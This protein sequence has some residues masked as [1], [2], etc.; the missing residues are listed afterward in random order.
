MQCKCRTISETPWY[1]HP[2][3]AAHC[4]CLFRL[5]GNTL[6]VGE[7]QSQSQTQTE[8]MT[9]NDLTQ[10]VDG[11]G[12]ILSPPHSRSPIHLSQIPWGKLMPTDPEFVAKDKN[13]VVGGI[14]LLPKA[15]EDP[16]RIDSK[17]SPNCETTISFLG[18]DGLT[19]RDV[20]N[21]YVLGRNGRNKVSIPKPPSVNDE[22]MA[23][24]NAWAHALISNRHCR[25]FC[26]L[27]DSSSN[28]TDA[29]MEVY[30]EDTSNNGTLVNGS[31]VLRRGEKRLLHTGDEICLLTPQTLRKKIRAGEIMNEIQ[32]H[33]TFIFINVLQQKGGAIGSGNAPTMPAP[34]PLP[35]QTYQDMLPPPQPLSSGRKRGGLVNVRG[36]ANH[37][38]DRMPSPKRLCPALDA[39]HDP[40]P[41]QSDEGP[42]PTSLSSS[43]SSSSSIPF[44]LLSDSG[45]SDPIEG[46]PKGNTKNRQGQPSVDDKPSTIL[47]AKAQTNKA[48]TEQQQHQQPPP[49][50]PLDKQ[51]QLAQSSLRVEEVYDIRDVLGTGTC[52]EVRRAI[53]RRTG[54]ERAVKIISFG[55]RNKSSRISAQVRAMIEA[56]AN[57]LRSLHHPY[58]V[59]LYDVFVAPGS[60]VYLV[61]EL[62]NG[63]DLF[64][65]I[66]AKGRYSEVES[67]RT[68]RRLLNAIYYLHEEQNVVHRDLKPEN[69]LC[70]SK[71]N[72][73]DVKLTD[74][75]VAKAVTDEGLKTFCGTPQYFAPEV[76]RRQH[77]IAGRGRYG[78]QA[79][80]WSVGVILYIL[81]SGAPPFDL[82]DGFDVVADAKVS[83]SSPEWDEISSEAIDLVKQCLK[84]DPSDRISAVDACNHPWILVDD[85]DSH[86]HPLDDPKSRTKRKRPSETTT[87]AHEPTLT[88]TKKPTDSPSMAA[89]S[90]PSLST[91]KEMD[92]NANSP[93]TR[94]PE[95]TSNGAHFLQKNNDGSNESL[96]NPV[97]PTDSTAT[98]K[99]EQEIP[100]DLHL[101]GNK[102]REI[103]TASAEKA[104]RRKVMKEHQK[105][106][107]SKAPDQS[108]GSQLVNDSDGDTARSPGDPVT[109][110]AIALSRAVTSKTS[111][112][113]GANTSICGTQS[114]KG[115][116]N[117]GK[118]SHPAKRKQQYRSIPASEPPSHDLSD[119]GIK[120]E[121]SDDIESISSFGTTECSQGGDKEK[122][123]VQASVLAASLS[124]S[125]SPTSNRSPTKRRRKDS[126]GL[127]IARKSKKRT[128]TSRR[129][130]AT[131]TTAD[132]ND[133]IGGNK[134]TKL[135]AWFSPKKDGMNTE[136][137]AISN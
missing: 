4:V 136:K 40:L 93:E 78:K 131:N 92:D 16:S 2:F 22:R 48:S 115:V 123:T 111:K 3:L 81:L 21:E 80:M 100:T 46:A 75:G 82:T 56:E 102:F 88:T 86:R 51:T 52:G 114:T 59:K 38:I 12:S 50:K 14:D 27:K 99:L 28:S 55:G 23:R 98:T 69:I 9:Q 87:P 66:V 116:P 42:K 57:I 84:A 107:V 74:F 130:K 36:V 135:S 15:P 19:K 6:Q 26:M 110:D 10:L 137:E 37:S 53:H 18:L 73:I 109:T 13:S 90:S 49:H 70:V 64:D 61:M 104:N 68:M 7:S 83:Y 60:A 118:D 121:F 133:N 65:R 62:M 5:Y 125:S 20:F 31:T 33:Y 134:Q 67:R 91:E 54:E 126:N 101:R 47:K 32:R 128:R 127:D 43:S 77:T 85:G 105:A 71:T 58:I 1:L 95:T 97:S 39:S 29:T 89:P 76:L 106:D 103:I 117:D 41:K 72:D 11:D 24:V 96:P 122:S 113:K 30:I 25:I 8:L 17:D 63:G 108:V 34:F 45:H 129:R 112:R 124:P 94:A 132:V 119:D 120:S 35:S 44:A 79:D